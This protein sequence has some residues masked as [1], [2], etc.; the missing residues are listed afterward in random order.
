MLL[1]SWVLSLPNCNWPE[2]S[3]EYATK[4][5]TECAC[6][7]IPEKTVAG[8]C[9]LVFVA[10][11]PGP[12]L[13]PAVLRLAERVV[14]AMASGQQW[15][16]SKTCRMKGKISKDEKFLRELGMEDVAQYINRQSLF[17]DRLILTWCVLP[18]KCACLPWVW[19]NAQQATVTNHL[20]PV[21]N[22]G[23]CLS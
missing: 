4:G 19:S 5:A 17:S 2:V 11:P 15:L 10:G 23:S 21:L 1:V 6:W 7:N 18:N 9:V 22:K 13:D 12:L 14:G 16:N 20:L 8:V 3:L